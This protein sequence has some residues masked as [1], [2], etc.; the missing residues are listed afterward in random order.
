MRL[1]HLPVACVLLVA[2]LL[3]SAVEGGDPAKD[4]KSKDVT[5]RLAAVGLLQTEGGTSAEALL[6]DAL[7]DTDWE[8]VERA[9][10]ALATRGTAESVKELAGLAMKGPVRRIR[11]RA[12]Q[13]VAALDAE[14]AAKLLSKDTNGDAAL[15]ATEAL[16]T[17]AQVTGEMAGPTLRKAIEKGLKAKEA[18]VRAAAAAGLAALPEADRRER[19]SRLLGDADAVVAARALAEAT[20]APDPA[21]L[22][23][24]ADQLRRPELDDV[25]ERRV[26]TAIEAALATLPDEAGRTERF[27]EVVGPVANEKDALVSGR[28]ARLAGVLASPRPAPRAEGAAPPPAAGG[29]PAPAGPAPAAPAPAPPAPPPPAPPLVAPHAALAALAGAVQH[30]G[31]AARAL[32]MQA[33]GRI[34][35]KSALDIAAG[36]A[37]TDESARVRR[38]ALRALVTGRGVADDATRT[39]VTGRLGQDTDASVREEAAVLLGV[40]APDK[41]PFREPAAA[42]EKALDDADWGVA[43][44]AAVSAGKTRNPALVAALQRMLDPKRVK[45]WRRRGAAVVGL[46]LLRERAAVAPMIEALGDKDLSV[47]RTA[48]EY[49][50]RLTTRSTSRSGTCGTRGGRA[51]RRPTSSSIPRR[52]PGRRSRAGTPR[53]PSRSTTSSTSWCSRAGATTSSRCSTSSASRTG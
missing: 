29:G 1:R 45:D 6:V 4:L 47:R 22:V 10:E 20:R 46:G 28:A 25:L 9:A 30:K 40:S 2:T 32:A 8:V 23:P 24:L 35:T 39:I 38:A 21:Y 19:L 14:G 42:L 13:S 53:R 49:L 7:G 34:G 48:F 33:L 27:R 18:S 51:T 50:R 41:G 31:P 52:S 44:C 36:L 15:R 3:P 26:A 37:T 16:A 11:R 5:V 17:L 12:A 43:V